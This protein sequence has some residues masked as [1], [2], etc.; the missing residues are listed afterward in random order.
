MVLG[1]SLEDAE[2]TTHRM[3]GLLPV[4]TSYARRRLHPRGRPSASV[5]SARASSVPGGGVSSLA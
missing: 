4:A 1:E 5:T 2:G 3:A